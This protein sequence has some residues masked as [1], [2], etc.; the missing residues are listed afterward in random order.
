MDRLGF[1]GIDGSPGSLKRAHRRYLLKR[2]AL[3]LGMV[4][5]ILSAALL[6]RDMSEQATSGERV[7]PDQTAAFG[8]SGVNSLT[9]LQAFFQNIDS[10][11]SATEA[12]EAPVAE[13]SDDHNQDARPLEGPILVPE[14][15]GDASA[16]LTSS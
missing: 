13:L 3:F 8:A 9:A 12:G 7:P 6:E 1:C 4:L 2:S 11:L 15:F 10:S 14:Y 5:V 16:S